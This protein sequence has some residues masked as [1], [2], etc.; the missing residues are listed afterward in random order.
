MQ[1]FALNFRNAL[2]FHEQIKNV[3]RLLQPQLSDRRTLTEFRTLGVTIKSLGPNGWD[4]S[5]D[6]DATSFV[7]T[8]QCL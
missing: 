5:G 7:L 4:M 8:G 6:E 2:Y 1:K 3:C